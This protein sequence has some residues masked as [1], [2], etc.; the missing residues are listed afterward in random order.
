MKK[1]PLNSSEQLFADLRDRN[2]NAVGSFL[3]QRVKLLRV[4]TD[5]RLSDVF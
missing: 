5:V 4:E 2:F 3:S 1:I